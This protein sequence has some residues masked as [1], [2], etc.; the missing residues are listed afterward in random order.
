M[1]SGT[2]KKEEQQVNL[3]HPGAGGN[4]HDES[5]MFDLPDA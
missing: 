5:I 4:R 2:F 3:P 1:V